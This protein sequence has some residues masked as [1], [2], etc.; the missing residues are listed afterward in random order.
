MRLNAMLQGWKEG[1]TSASASEQ[2]AISQWAQGKAVIAD[3][4]ELEQA[5]DRFD[6]WRRE[7]GLY[8]PLQSYEIGTV[9]RVERQPDPYTAVELK[10]NGQRQTV[11]VPDD[12]KP[13]FWAGR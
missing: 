8:G 1:G 6:R 13:I 10:L 11:G 4:D 3:R 12:E 9:S 5:M 2:T 7:R